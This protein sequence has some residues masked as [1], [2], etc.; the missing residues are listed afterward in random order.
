MTS[1][2]SYFCYFA[3][4]NV[5]FSPIHRDNFQRKFMVRSENCFKWPR[6]RV[7][8]EF[9]CECG[10]LSGILCVPWIVERKKVN[11]SG[12]LFKLQH[13]MLVAHGGRYSPIGEPCAGY[14]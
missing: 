3:L 10:W 12:K 8:F 5:R 11:Y 6:M 4:Y 9:I 14:V 7:Y 13:L 1:F 2:G